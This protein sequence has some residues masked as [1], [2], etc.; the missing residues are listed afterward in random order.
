MPQVINFFLCSS[1]SSLYLLCTFIP[2][3]LHIHLFSHY[4][5]CF[6]FIL[7]SIG[8]LLDHV[9]FSHA[10]AA[11]LQE[12]AKNN[13]TSIYANLNQIVHELKAKY[14]LLL[15]FLFSSFLLFYF[16]FDFCRYSLS[17]V[18]LLTKNFHILPYFHGNR[19]P[20][21]DPHAVGQIYG[22]KVTFSHSFSIFPLLLPFSFSFCP[23]TN[24]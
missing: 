22:L 13:N 23:N 10:A 7:N 17:H 3:S 16:V 11:T 5:V 2:R 14:P 19:S 20:R 4:L 24:L 1:S 21:A 15:S 6:L 8:A 12:K 18:A 9:I